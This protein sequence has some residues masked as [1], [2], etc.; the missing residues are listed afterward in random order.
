MP[1]T[2]RESNPALVG[3]ITP[4]GGDF[5][6]CGIETLVP[7]RRFEKKGDLRTR[8]MELV[9]HAVGF[10]DIRAISVL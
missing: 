3:T 8:S 9:R 1:R 7:G 6:C 5:F 2:G 4:G 10:A